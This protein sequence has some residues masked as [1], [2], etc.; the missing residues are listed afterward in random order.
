MQLDHQT[1]ADDVARVVEAMHAYG[2][3]A[4]TLRFSPLAQGSFLS[5][6]PLTLPQ[7]RTLGIIA[8]AG[9]TGRSGRELASLLGVGPSAITPLVDRLVEHGFANRHEDPI[10]RRI[11]RVRATP[12]GV[13]VLERVANVHHEALAEIVKRIHP[14]DLQIVERSLVILSEAVSKVL[15][16]QATHV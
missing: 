12:Q 7:L 16:E 1:K 14:D 9:A 13:Q 11:L 6:L 2:R 10:D 8:C 3:L 5:D 15:A 4:Q